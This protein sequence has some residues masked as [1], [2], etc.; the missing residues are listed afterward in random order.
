MRDNAGNV[1]SKAFAQS[2][3][4]PQQVT[5]TAMPAQAAYGDT[6]QAA[7]QGASGQPAT[8]TAGP[9]RVCTAT[10]PSKATITMV[11]VG[12][13]VV[14][15]DLAED[16]GYFAA[17]D[18]RTITVTKASLTIAADKITR[19]YGSNP[20][21]YTASYTGLV[22][23]DT[24]GDLTSP[25][26]T[27]APASSSVGTYPIRV[28]G[29]TNPNYDVKYVD[30]VETVTKA[31]LTITAND[32]TR[33]YGA[34]APAY[35]AKITGLVN[36][37]TAGD[38]TSPSF[39]GAP[40]S[41]SV[42]T[43][44]IRVSGAT[45]PDYDV[46]YVDGV[47]TVTKAPLTITAN[48]LTRTYGATAPAY[49][50]KITGLVNG[51]QDNDVTY[52]V[53]G[54]PASSGVGTYPIRVSGVTNPNYEVAYVDGVETVTKAPLTIAADSITRTYG[55]TAPAYSAKITGLVNGDQASD[56]PYTVTGPPASSAVG[57][58][59]VTVLPDANPNYDI[60]PVHGTVTVTAADL[61][62]TA[63]DATIPYGGTAVLAWTGSGWVNGDSDSTLGA[64]PQTQAP[65][66]SATVNG[67]PVT[68]T[69]P[70]GVYADA[71][72]CDGA[73]IPNYTI[74]YAN[75]SLS[76]NPVVA[77]QGT[78]TVD[79]GRSSTRSRDV[80]LSLAATNA[81]TGVTQMRFSNDG[82]TW[83]AYRPYA[84]TAA[85]SLSGADGTKTVYAQFADASGNVLAVASDTIALDS[86]GP[87]AVRITPR[88]RAKN[89]SVKAQ[90]E[91][92]VSEAVTATGIDARSVVLTR[93]GTKV[94]AKVV[95]R[96]ARHSI[97]LRPTEPLK[98][99]TYHLTIR[100]T[101]TDVLGNRWDDS[102]SKRGLQPTR[103]TFTV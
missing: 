22:N 52:T 73:A 82:S 32:L 75:G 100:T 55:A 81:G 15:A 31:P 79:D 16:A 78:V 47:E 89:A 63:T 45:N 101:I 10:G 7:A 14:D 21:S 51:D 94:S 87:R 44:P 88:K 41:S 61:T 39:T 76:V 103:S 58:Y 2:V 70:P 37:D 5:W 24:A 1:V 23:G 53:A 71:I 13:C 9:A 80:Q 60:T 40:A 33:T 46:K 59:P 102:Q 54:P 36:G 68:S 29:V 18:R 72:A 96:P 27:G 20:P 86:T 11:G 48:D 67:N 25:S 85:W 34:T 74:H 64:A 42:G 35:S 28:S 8:F 57:T 92:V 19:V 43:Y 62:I 49:S 95:Y 69:T 91:V 3:N 99:G 98:A 17:R 30:G 97:L 65:T 77:P 50:A 84:A 4:Q 6:V 26:F 56:F 66:C 83:S 90:V 12:Y 93:N 38:L